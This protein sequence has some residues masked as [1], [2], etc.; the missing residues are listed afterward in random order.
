M[1]A[2]RGIRLRWRAST[3]GR[4]AAA[5]VNAKNSSTISS[6]SFQRASAVTT[7]AA[8]T[9]AITN[10]R[11]AISVTQEVSPPWGDRKPAGNRHV[12]GEPRGV[13]ADA[14]EEIC[15]EARRHGIVLV[16]PLV[17]SVVLASMGGVLVTLPR[18]VSLAGA[19]VV[20]LGALVALRAVWKWE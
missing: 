12:G 17:W 2:P 8:T 20:A 5:I 15:L 13:L 1:P 4:S 6:F 7:T 10:A 18:P 14:H 3:E 19:V 11:R 9:A 16:R